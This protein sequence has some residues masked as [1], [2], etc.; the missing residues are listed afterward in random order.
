MR[1]PRLFACSLLL[2]LALLAGLE[3]Q[4]PPTR[5][6]PPADTET[7][8]FRLPFTEPPGPDTW[9]LIQP[10]GNTTFAFTYRRLVYGAGQ[11]FTSASTWRRAAALPSSPSAMAW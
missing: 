6:A 8:P 3:P 10:Y 11:G 9:L 5:A 7:P 2:A 1:R 4:V